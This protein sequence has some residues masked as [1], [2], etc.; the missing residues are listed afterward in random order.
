MKL[1]SEE[2]DDLES[3]LLS[4]GWNVLG[5]LIDELT[6]DSE[7]AVL[8]YLIEGGAEGLVHAKCKY[9][10]ARK[11]NRSIQDLKK[12]YLKKQS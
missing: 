1:S 7:K 3:L 2:R 8:N 10:G 6:R 4:E 5:K 11:L 9:E 12:V